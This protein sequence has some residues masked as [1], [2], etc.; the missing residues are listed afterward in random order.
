M[1]L[2]FDIHHTFFYHEWVILY[3]KT[4]FN[5]PVP[6]HTKLT[7]LYLNNIVSVMLYFHYESS[8]VMDRNDMLIYTCHQEKGSWFGERS[9][10]TYANIC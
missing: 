1:C 5:C 2:N 4:T 8:F 10:P 9:R 3:H 6:F 7:S